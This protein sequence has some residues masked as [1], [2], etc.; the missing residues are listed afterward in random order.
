MS[1]DA[2]RVD[3]VTIMSGM[4]REPLRDAALVVKLWRNLTD[5]VSAADALPRRSHSMLSIH[6]ITPDRVGYVI[7]PLLA[8]AEVL[9]QNTLS[10]VL[11]M[12]R[13]MGVS[14]I[15]FNADLAHFDC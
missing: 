1:R 12:A 15:C 5:V 10:C 8:S 2:M 4:P 7:K 9:P 13:V 14:T 6:V 11:S 3:G